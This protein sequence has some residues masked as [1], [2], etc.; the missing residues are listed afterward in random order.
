MKKKI[1]IRIAGK[2]QVHVIGVGQ[3]EYVVEKDGGTVLTM[4]VTALLEWMDIMDV[5]LN[6]VNMLEVCRIWHTIL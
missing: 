1:V 6:Q 5:F 4:D 2:K 3:M